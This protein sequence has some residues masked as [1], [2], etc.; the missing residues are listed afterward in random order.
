MV[1]ASLVV[2]SAMA[3]G[4]TEQ[5]V[6]EDLCLLASEKMGNDFRGSL[7]QQLQSEYLSAYVRNGMKE[8]DL[9][10]GKTERVG[11]ERAVEG[12]I[13]GRVHMP[14]PLKNT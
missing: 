3:L 11:N 4:N 8:H 12:R 2:G 1:H 5:W 9:A 10:S 7:M 14:R 13:A 6:S